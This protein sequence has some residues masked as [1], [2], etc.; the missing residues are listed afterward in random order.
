MKTD[1]LT[2]LIDLDMSPEKLNQF[3]E[4][5]TNTNENKGQQIIDLLPVLLKNTKVRTVFQNELKNQIELI[6][7][8]K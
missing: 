7:E 6:G 3:L 1:R 5:S 8:I 2:I 4:L